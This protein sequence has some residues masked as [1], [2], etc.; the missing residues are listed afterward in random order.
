M[1]IILLRDVQGLGKKDD[2]KEVK[3]GYALNLL[4]PQG[5]AIIAGEKEISMAEEK[6][7]RKE[8]EEEQRLEIMNSVFDSLN[9]KSFELK[10]ATNDKG[11]MFSKLHLDEVLQ[12]IENKLAK[13]IIKLPEIKEVGKFDIPI[14]LEKRKGKFILEIK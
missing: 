12:L 8:K 14:E 13:E 1:K 11:H 10:V 2:I 4:I 7:L 9:G 6:K 5:L 3:S